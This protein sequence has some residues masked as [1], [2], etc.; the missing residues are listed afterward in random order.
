MNLRQIFRRRSPAISE[1]QALQIAYQVCQEREWL[2]LEPVQATLT[3]HGWCIHTNW[4]SRGV[5]AR[6]IIHP[7]TGSVVS[8]QFWPR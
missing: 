8:A 4:T 5:N 1:A 7:Q 6:I 3:R 2:W